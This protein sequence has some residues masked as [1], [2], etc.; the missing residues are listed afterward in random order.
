MADGHIHR[1]P[2]QAGRWRVGGRS[3]IGRACLTGSRPGV[4]NTTVVAQGGL[5]AAFQHET[6]L[7]TTPLFQTDDTR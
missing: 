2:G 1:S 4:Y 3:P 5:L 7:V 6:N